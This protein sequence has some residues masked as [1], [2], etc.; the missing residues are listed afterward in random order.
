MAGRRHAWRRYA[1]GE[2]RDLLLKKQRK[3]L[4]HEFDRAAVLRCFIM[5]CFVW[6]FCVPSAHVP[7]NKDMRLV[8]S[9]LA[10][11]PKIEHVSTSVDHVVHPILFEILQCAFYCCPAWLEYW[12]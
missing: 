3:V 9:H 2:R 4:Y 1:L 5:F 10:V 12:Q 11:A 7:L 8:V 6:I